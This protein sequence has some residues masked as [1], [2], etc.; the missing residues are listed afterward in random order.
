MNAVE[1][2]VEKLVLKELK[3][4]NE[5]FP[6]FYSTHEGWAVLCEEVGELT[7]ESDA[8][9]MLEDKLW[10]CVRHNTDGTEFVQRIYRRAVNAACEAIQV[11]AMALKYMELSN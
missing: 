6:A 5:K 8:A 3:A 1:K 11:A 4:S 7:H 9:A 2:D 10:S